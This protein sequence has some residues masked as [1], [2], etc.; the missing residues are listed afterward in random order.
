[1]IVFGVVVLMP[2]VADGVA[3]GGGP[4]LPGAAPPVQ[5]VADAPL[6]WYRTPWAVAGALLALAGVLFLLVKGRTAY[7]EQRQEQLERRVAEQTRE[8]QEQKHQVEAY[9][10][11]LVR[12]N[13]VLRRT[14]EEKSQLLGMAAHDLKNPLFGIRALSEIV[15]ESGELSARN[16]RKVAL[17]RA[18]AH[19][20]LDLIDDLLASAASSAAGEPERRPVDVATL[21]RWVEQ[22]FQPQAERKGQTLR[23]A[24]PA[25]APCVVEGDKGKL[26]EALGN[27]VSNA[28]KYSPPDEAVT[29]AVRRGDDTVRVSVQDDGPGLSEADQKRMFAPFQRLT[30]EPTG[31]EG[32]SGLGL[33]IVKQ[34][35]R[36]HDGR[37]EVD[38]A[39]GEGSTFTLVLPAASIE[40]DPVP[41][42]EPSDVDGP[43]GAAGRPAPR[44]DGSSSKQG[45]RPSR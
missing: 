4:V 32:S 23:C 30:P 34:I 8:V 40:A 13:K 39:P 3:S 2:G 21:T 24:V 6:P 44:P 17:I 16:E 20:T 26:R 29:V 33:Y 10:R 45:L 25:E 19:E 27:L 7:L 18:S 37:V 31:D 14:V 28:L 11:E 22:S 38:T 43:D 41:E 9:N 35:A 1:V 15:L 42:V 5:A 12:T 36:M